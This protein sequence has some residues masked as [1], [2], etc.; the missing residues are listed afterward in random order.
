MIENAKNLIAMIKVESFLS[1]LILVQSLILLLFVFILLPTLLNDN[2][3][4]DLIHCNIRMVIEKSGNS[5]PTPTIIAL[6]FADIGIIRILILFLFLASVLFF[7]IRYKKGKAKDIYY[8]IFS[9]FCLTIG[10]MFII[11]CLL[12]FI[13]LC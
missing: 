2:S 13:P 7:E 10:F 4:D 6:R 11:A 1:R 8:L 9:I 5:L 12:P 3:N